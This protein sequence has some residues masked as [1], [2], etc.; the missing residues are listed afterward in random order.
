MM[1]YGWVMLIVMVAVVLMWQWGVFN[2][3]SRVEPGS[4]G[5]WGVQVA[6]GN[7]FKLDTDGVMRVAVVNTVGGNVT[8]LSANL[9]IGTF[10]NDCNPPSGS[11][12]LTKSGASNRLLP[13]GEIR[14]LR[15]QNDLFKDAAGNRFEAYLTIQYNDTRT[16][17]N[18]YQ[19]SGRIWG[20]IE[21]AT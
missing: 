5:F 8:I 16:G 7:D 13:T 6:S 19:S 17:D 12:V 18:T 20:N 2:Y 15:F 3:G 10:R 1:T 21:P 14:I 9:T 4:F 11:C